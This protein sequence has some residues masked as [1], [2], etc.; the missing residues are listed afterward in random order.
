M[1][2]S[3]AYNTMVYNSINYLIDKLS[4]SSTNYSFTLFLIEVK[5]IITIMSINYNTIIII[6]NMHSK[7]DF[8]YISYAKIAFTIA[9]I[10]CFMVFIF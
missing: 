4:Y 1:D 6:N 8:N 3:V 2:N 10:S 5:V 7:K 9:F